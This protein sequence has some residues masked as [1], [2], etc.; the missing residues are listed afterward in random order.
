MLKMDL[1][2]FIYIKRIL[3]ISTTHNKYTHTTSLAAFASDL[4][5]C[6]YYKQLSD[7]FFL[8]LL[9]ST[10]L[11]PPLFSECCLVTA[12]EGL[13][14]W[15]ASYLLHTLGRAGRTGVRGQVQ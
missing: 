10:S 3:Q 9:Y 15:R 11:T 1:L 2:K 4:C 14:L 5:L 8:F 12:D 7:P 6:H 13:L